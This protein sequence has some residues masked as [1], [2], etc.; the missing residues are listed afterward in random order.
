MSLILSIDNLIQEVA[1]KALPFKTRANYTLNTPLRTGRVVTKS[2]LEMIPGGGSVANALY[3]KQKPNHTFNPSNNTKPPS[4][5]DAIKNV[6]IGAS[7]IELSKI[8]PGAGIGANIIKNGV[9]EAVESGKARHELERLSVIK[10]KATENVRSKINTTPSKETLIDTNQN[11]Y[12][13]A[14]K[15]QAQI[16]QSHPQLC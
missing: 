9:S 8:I 4:V 14:V 11:R 13:L 10:Q 5:K 2:L 7:T 6:A 1:W 3:D 12:N 16:C 15:R